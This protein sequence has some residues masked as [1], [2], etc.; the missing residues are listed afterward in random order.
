MPPTIANY[1]ERDTGV[2]NGALLPRADRRRHCYLERRRRNV[3]QSRAPVYDGYATTA[4]GPL[5][6]AVRGGPLGD[7][8]A[9]NLAMP[10]RRSCGPVGREVW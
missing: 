5:F 6:G 4:T 3:H 10:G 8:G 2:S 1:L 7:L 9:D